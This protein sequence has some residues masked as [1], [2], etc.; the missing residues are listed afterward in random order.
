MSNKKVLAWIAIIT[1]LAGTII[2]SL[3]AAGVISDE[4]AGVGRQ[5]VETAI[6]DTNTVVPLLEDALE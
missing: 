5:I 4:E 2:G 3:V 6:S 1:V